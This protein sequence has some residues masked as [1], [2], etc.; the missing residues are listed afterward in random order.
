MSH[1]SEQKTIA[2]NTIFLYLRMFVVMFVSLFT[3]R[4]VL[5]KLGVD[6]Y[7][8]YN[9]VGSIVVSFAF[10]KNSLMSATQRFFSYSK[11]KTDDCSKVFS[12]SINIQ[13]LVI[14]IALVLLE[15]LGLWFL[16]NIIK[17]PYE[18]I[19]A[20][21]VVYQLSVFTFC[22][23][24]LQVPY[25]AA[26]VSNEKMSIYA[27]L[28]ILD[29]TIKLVIVYALTVTSEID[30]LI[31]YGFLMLLATL[32][33]N[34]AVMLYCHTKL[35]NDCRYLFKWEKNLFRELLSFSTWNLLG[36]LSGVANTEGPNYLIN[37]YLGVKVNAAMGVAKQ[38]SNAVYSFSANFQTAF[39]PQIVKAYA[40]GEITYLNSLI[41]RSSKLSFLLVFILAV[42]LTICSK[43]ILAT[44][45]VEVPEYTNSFCILILISQCIT[46]LSSPLWMAAHAIGNIKK[47]QMILVFFN[48]LVFPLSWIILAIGL[49]PY[50]VIVAQI[51]LAILVMVYRI[52]YLYQKIHFPARTYTKEVVA[53]SI[54]ICLVVIPSLLA[55]SVFLSGLMKILVVIGISIIMILSL[56][57]FVGLDKHERAYIKRMIY[58]KIQQ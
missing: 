25:Y 18:R 7:G 33:S 13:L 53:K 21:N 57:Y 2:K 38:V 26:V 54:G 43:E 42:P 51:L 55:I 37:Y 45:L 6:D 32:L 30:K 8:I 3:S 10:V 49:E 24:L 39:N 11:G 58:S 44:W 1:G 31:L 47:Y 16:N 40:S 29:V 22:V 12:A 52:H 50:Y 5:D 56:F 34:I 35:R 36:G 14:I 17:I 20:A 46:A 28:S 23:N 4:V 9:I 19:Y 15:T 41:F 27:F 48:V